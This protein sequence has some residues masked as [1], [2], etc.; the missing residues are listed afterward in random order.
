[1][2]PDHLAAARYPPVSAPARWF[3]PAAAVMPAPDP[4]AGLPE[5]AGRRLD[6]VCLRPI[7][8][9]LEYEQLF[10]LTA[11]LRS[12]LPAAALHLHL[13]SAMRDPAPFDLLPVDRVTR[14]AGRYGRG[15]LA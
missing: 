1:M 7:H 13:L 6:V 4:F 12:R 5:P 14:L 9:V 2:L 3:G 15:V 11:A 8:H 10:R